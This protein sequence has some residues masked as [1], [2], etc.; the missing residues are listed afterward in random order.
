MSWVAALVLLAAGSH[1][2]AQEKDKPDLD[3]LPQK[4]KDTLKAKFPKAEIHKLT[5][6]KEGDTVIYDLE[7]KQ[8]GRKFEA[9]IKEDGTIVNWEKEIAAKDLP[10]AV[11]KAVEKKYPKA[12]L[13]EVMEITA[14]K[15]N[16]DMLEG[17]EV[18]LDTADNKEVELTLAPD[19]K[20]LEEDTGEKKEK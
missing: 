12:K 15:D 20:I 7:F 3:K 16:K 11:T 14:V 13:K 19:G 17:Y 8:E 10:E 4:V 2:P 6:E 18:V 9:D 5:K 1:A